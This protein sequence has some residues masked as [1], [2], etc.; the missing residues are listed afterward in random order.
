MQE[1]ISEAEYAVMEVLWNEA[2]LT[3]TQVAARVPNGRNWTLATVK[4]LLS[5]LIAKSAIAHKADGRRYFYTPL[6]ER[7]H[8][9]AG[10]SSRLL[11]RLF[12]GRASPLFAH[13]AERQALSDEDIVEIEKLLQEMKS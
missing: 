7:E 9:V 12:G 1:R 4:T 5:R 2:P 8:Y 10:E 3:A 6:V 13:L 11:D